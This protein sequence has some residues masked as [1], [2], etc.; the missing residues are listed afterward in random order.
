MRTG[1]LLRAALLAGLAFVPLSYWSPSRADTLPV[2]PAATAG[3]P[4]RL[5]ASWAPAIARGH[6]TRLGLYQQGA[7]LDVT[8]PLRPRDPAGLSALAQAVSDP[9]SPLYGRYL[10]Y[11]Q[12]VDR[13]GP[14]RSSV[15]AVAAWLRGQ[16]IGGVA[17]Q[18]DSVSFRA[19]AA[20]LGALFGTEIDSWRLSSGR[21]IFGPAQAPAVPQA[22][23]SSV[24]AVVGL[25]DEAQLRPH[26]VTR[27]R[28]GTARPSIGSGVAGGY[29][30]AELR[31][32]YDTTSVISG[33]IDG[34][35][36]T[37]DLY[38][39]DGY[40]P[41]DVSTYDAQYGITGTTVVPY[42]CQSD[43]SG[44]YTCTANSVMAPT[45]GGG[46]GG[47]DE[48]ESDIEVAQ[49]M[50]PRATIHVY[51]AA[52]D[53]SDEFNLWQALIS[54]GDAHVVSTSWGGCELDQP[55]G[56]QQ[57][58]DTRFQ[59]AVASGVGVFAATG[60]TGSNDCLLDTGSPNQFALAVDNP[61]SDPNVTGVGGTSLLLNGSDNGYGGESVW[62]DP[63]E[64]AGGGGVSA[65][66]TAPWYQ[67]GLNPPQLNGAGGRMVPDISAN[68]AYSTPYSVYT[69]GVDQFGN[70]TAPTWTTLGGTSLAAPLWAALLTLANQSLAAGG[71]Q[72]LGF[73]N[74]ALYN[75]AKGASS[76]SIFHDITLGNNDTNPFDSSPIY[77]S[78][79]GYD[80][81]SG[82][83]SAD[84]ANLIAALDTTTTPPTPT[85]TPV[86]SG[87]SSG[88]YE[89]FVGSVGDVDYYVMTPTVGGSANVAT[90]AVDT[91]AQFSLFVYDD[92]NNL[93]TSSATP[94][95]CQWVSLAVSAGQSYIVK[96]VA[97][98]LNPSDLLPGLYTSAWNVNGAPVVWSVF[99]D[100]VSAGASQSFSFPTLSG[101]SMVLSTCGPSGTNFDLYLLDAQNNILHSST[102][103][104][105]CQ[106]FSY[107]AG[108]RGQFQLQEQSVSGTG[109]WTGYITT[110]LGA[111]VATN[112]PTPTA[113]SPSSTATTTPP[114][115][116]PTN[117]PVPPSST[118]T[119]TPTTVSPAPTSTPTNVPP[120]PTSTPTH[121]VMPPANTATNTPI[122]PVSTATNT[123]I[124]P[125]PTATRTPLPPTS[126]PTTAPA[127]PTSTATRI[128]VSH[129][130]TATPTSALIVLPAAHPTAGAKRAGRPPLVFHLARRSVVSG[131]TLPVQ[132]RT[133]AHAQ[134]T[135]L[136]QVVS[137]K[138]TFSGTGK[139]RKRITHSTV[140][141]HATLKGRA[142][143][144]GTFSGHLRITY[145]PKKATPAS[146]A[147]SA[148]TAHGTARVTARLTIQPPPRPKAR[149]H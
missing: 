147:V 54:A 23:A 34:S 29:T 48:V 78:A 94:S 3:P 52:N 70:P 127:V 81:A 110:D 36:Q 91:S 101:G 35:G 124:P 57:A 132:V 135:V 146:L 22:L 27:A 108:T 130:P 51:Q 17:A 28:A 136:L 63:G 118:P 112:T 18:A 68:A 39:L 7:V 21:T 1:A 37:I 148:H 121:S 33:G 129:P 66:F 11:A 87:P 133:A 49:A 55:F 24:A 142:G 58:L 67:S 99:G 73:A 83:G 113:T 74:P 26:V 82:W 65:I 97:V 71:H 102:T 122:P 56:L 141:Y 64:G 76:T 137:T 139:H 92:A 143:A 20:R 61:A 79:S 84:G 134:V 25:D 4:V 106:S 72:P 16:G 145:K 44:V 144:H 50:A 14:A 6:A 9:T 96:T 59:Y 105:N 10:S 13:Y 45:A 38:E 119:S 8:M 98:T 86:T 47:Q 80:L 30:P 2:L 149:K 31:D 95:N 128:P 114:T 126:T 62:N 69:M 103:P 89:G 116:T 77:V 93:I 85:S 88:S 111:G 117:T 115:S 60:D 53:E 40:D 19:P 104:S 125:V 75:L 5:T 100:I 140:L 131:A 41:A 138:V 46:A 12:L 90:C 107:V 109:V 120:V 123:P 43:S 42:Q 32:A 15:A